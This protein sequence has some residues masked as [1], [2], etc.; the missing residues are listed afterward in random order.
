M[1][2]RFDSQQLRD[3]MAATQ[4]R[5]M[6]AALMYAK[7]SALELQNHAKVNAP[8]TDRTSMARTTL[9]ADAEQKTDTVIQIWLAHGVEYGIWLELANNK[10]YAIIQPTIDLKSQAIF[11]G[12]AGLMN[13]INSSGGR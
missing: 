9:S 7:T 5:T 8:W 11:N 6:T 4:S 13:R 1:G 3:G 10:K 2:F 12:F